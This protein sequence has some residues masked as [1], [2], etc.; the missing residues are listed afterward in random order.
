MEF[1]YDFLA[2]SSRKSVTI[3]DDLS[4]LKDKSLGDTITTY[5]WFCKK[6]RRCGPL[7]YNRP[8]FRQNLF[9]NEH[10]SKY[11][12]YNYIKQIK[13]DSPLLEE[14]NFFFNQKMHTSS[15]N[16]CLQKP[17]L[18][19]KTLFSQCS[20]FDDFLSTSFIKKTL[21]SPNKHTEKTKYVASKLILEKNLMKTSNTVE[22]SVFHFVSFDY[23]YF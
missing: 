4:K 10:P 16:Q 19:G 22:D 23:L 12:S 2:N 14:K 17:D 6:K 21:D 3:D 20:S 18:A 13:Q 9:R 5:S 15:T 7:L 1:I 8:N 11:S